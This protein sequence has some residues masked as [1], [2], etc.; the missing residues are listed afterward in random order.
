MT[1]VVSLQDAA[2]ADREEIGGKGWGLAKLK[3]AGF[4]VPDGFVVCSSA[5]LSFLD[6]QGVSKELARIHTEL[7]ADAAPD[8][9]RS[10]QRQ[11]SETLERASVPE[12]I[13]RPILDAYRTLSASLVA[14]RSSA[15]SEDSASASFAGQHRSFMNVDERNLIA[16]VKACWMSLWTTE[17]IEYRRRWGLFAEA[18]VRMAVIVQRMVAARVSGVAF[19]TDVVRQ[20]SG[21]IVV[22]AVEGMGEPLVGGTATPEEFRLPKTKTWRR[23]LARSKYS[24]LTPDEKERLRRIVMAVEA[25]FGSPQ[26]IEF[27]FEGQDLVILQSRPISTPDGTEQVPRGIWTRRGFDEWLRRPVSPLF[28][29][30][31]L[32]VLSDAADE[33]VRSRWK[34]QRSKPTW[35]ILHGFYYT[36]ASVKFN[37]ALSLVPL[38][39][40]RDA[41]HVLAGWQ[42][43]IAEYN[44][45][46]AALESAQS[47]TDDM[48]AV[49]AHLEECVALAARCWA[50]LVATG[51]VAK[52]LAL[53]ATTAARL[54]R[55]T[56]E[57][58]LA[59]LSGFENKSVEADDALWNL[60]REAR[61]DE[62]VARA[63]R[64]VPS[65]E[66]LEKIRGTPWAA[67]FR[68]WLSTYGVRLFD[69]DVAEASLDDR[70]ELAL[71]IVKA[72]MAKPGDSPKMRV[73][74]AAA[75]RVNA[76]HKLA[77]SSRLLR[78]SVLTIVRIAA[79]YARIREDRPYYLHM[80][81]PMIRRDLRACGKWL[82]GMGRLSHCDDVFF[83]EKDELIAALQLQRE[84]PSSAMSE[85][86]F[87]FIRRR[88]ERRAHQAISQPESTI[89]E[90]VM[91]G[92]LSVVAHRRR[93]FSR[94]ASPSLSGVSGNAGHARGTARI[95]QDETDFGRFHAGEILVARYTT[96]AWT[97]LFALAAGVVTE[98][99]GSLAHAA[100][101][102]REYGIPAVLGVEHLL[103]RISDGQGV[104]IDGAGGT[105][106]LLNSLAKGDANYVAT[107]SHK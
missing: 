46:V 88:R 73:T 96:P 78:G 8:V 28:G 84:R 50:W 81:W 67:E 104:E 98:V 49:A 90:G 33:I 80:L 92:L 100:I 82:V 58:A 22:N 14:V 41:N 74:A 61:E 55:L 86:L 87:P 16:S 93:R 15:T 53:I 59:L 68:N 30:L 37:A 56:A 2:F 63:L 60:A 99:G 103:D 43:F 101:I 85:S 45:K 12:E 107:T 34:L 75:R 20:N 5:F 94:R 47:P 39:V 65:E 21:V 4:T 71:D 32:P 72:W 25:S 66:V 6:S 9:V 18:Q 102:A 79:E 36:R 3:A 44:G 24:L 77:A 11:I 13:S 27:A 106:T 105:V 54:V 76:E 38:R 95:I 48:R 42:E 97:P 17:A 29:T 57:E 26:D 51:V 83:L 23:A 7:D 69:L 89:F 1:S 10:Y 91:A 52:A 62:T 70:P 35:V 31:M 64:E 19:S 40:W